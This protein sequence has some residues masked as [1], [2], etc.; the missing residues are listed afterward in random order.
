MSLLAR[1]QQEVSSKAASERDKHR[2]CEFS[3]IRRLHSFTTPSHRR[4]PQRHCALRPPTAGPLFGSLTVDKSLT[5]SRR[6]LALSLEA[7]PPTASISCS[8]PPPPRR[9]QPPL[10]AAA[11]HCLAVDN[12]TLLCLAPLPVYIALPPSNAGLSNLARPLDYRNK[13]I[14]Q[15]QERIHSLLKNSFINI[16][17]DIVYMLDPLGHRIRSDDWKHVVD[18]AMKMFHAVRERKK[19]AK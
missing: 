10:V 3:Y 17:K 1:E 8:R 7:S 12:L 15:R 14:C 4:S 11:L 16:N 13:V 18:M 6:P 19:R 5:C 2:R 9:R